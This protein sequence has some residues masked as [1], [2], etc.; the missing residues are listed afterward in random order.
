MISGRLADA[1]TVVI[2]DT[3]HMGPVT[4]AEAV[5]AEI[6]GLIR[7]AGGLLAQERRLDR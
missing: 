1:R 3:G 5:A 4:H 7:R 2:E 6:T